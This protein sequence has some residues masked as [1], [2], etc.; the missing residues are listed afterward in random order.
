MVRTHEDGWITRDVVRCE[1]LPRQSTPTS[2]TSGWL[3]RHVGRT[4]CERGWILIGALEVAATL[5][6]QAVSSVQNCE[7]VRPAVMSLRENE[8]VSLASVLCPCAVVVEVTHA[9]QFD[10]S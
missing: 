7:C 4:N 5:R 6:R 10:A 8:R 9:S 1:A 3:A 2:L